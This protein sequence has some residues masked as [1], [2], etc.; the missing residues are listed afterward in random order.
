MGRRN[1]PIKKCIVCGQ[2]IY[3]GPE[4]KFAVHEPSTRKYCSREC[5]MQWR[6]ENIPNF[7]TDRLHR[8]WQGMIERCT[9]PKHIS[10]DIYKSHGI[11]V[12]EEWSKDFFAFRN[13]ALENGYD[14]S[15]PRKEQSL[16]RI[17]NSKGYSP[18]NCRW[19][20]MMVNNQNT[21]RNVNITYNGK[22]Q[23]ISAWS[24]ELGLHI[25]TIRRRI[26]RNLPPE[27]ILRT[28][29]EEHK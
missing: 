23:C 29:E 5:Y 25:E 1:T 10:Y 14:Y 27:E 4:K 18:D 2:P 21:R 8:V 13:W 6:R 19:V 16:D 9:D 26:R 15:K 24:R 3:G 12:C 28:T 7:K 22:T 11:T 17:D 20:S